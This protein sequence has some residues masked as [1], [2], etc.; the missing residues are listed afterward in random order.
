MPHSTV[1]ANLV[2]H[3][4][5]L[6]YRKD[7]S[8][9]LDLFDDEAEVYEPFSKDGVVRGKSQIEPFL[10]FVTRDRVGVDYYINSILT[11]KKQAKELAVADVSFIKRGKTRYRFVFEF[12][13]NSRTGMISED[14]GGLAIKA[15]RIEL[16]D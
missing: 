6:F 13:G 8:G 15:L 10:R 1:V 12:G 3:C 7:V 14:A 5:N 11:I 16:P 2:R 9:L 4:F